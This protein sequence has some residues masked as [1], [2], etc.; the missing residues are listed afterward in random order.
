ME[1]RRCAASLEKP[2]DYCLSC[3]TA[4]CEAVV[5]EFDEGEATL[6][7]LYD[8]SVVG[9]STVATTPEPDE[10][11]AG[12]QRR[13]FAGRVADHVR[14]KRPEAVYVAGERELVAALREDLRYELYRVSDD[15]PVGTALERGEDGSLEVVEAAPGE[16]LGGSHSTVIGEREGHRVL[17]LVAEHPNVKKVVPGPIEAGGSSTRGG[18]RAK[19]TRADMNGNVRLL[20]REGSSVQENRIVTTATEKGDGERVRADLNEALVE[21]GYGEEG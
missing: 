21:A 19:V 14:R 17:M 13:N 5:V 9:E 16:K 3:D 6:T 18:V 20:L 12:V 10:E 7:M 4:N 11:L 1:C 8:G 15:D 2:G